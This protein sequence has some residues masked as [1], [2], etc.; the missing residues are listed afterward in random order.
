MVAAIY[1]NGVTAIREFA[2]PLMVGLVAGLFS[3]N[4]LTSP[5][6]YMLKRDKSKKQ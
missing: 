5:I 4:C 3:S 2:A 1:I 6:W